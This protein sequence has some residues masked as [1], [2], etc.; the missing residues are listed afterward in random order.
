MMKVLL[1]RLRRSRHR[2]PSRTD[3]A[4]HVN[5]PPGNAFG[6]TNILLAFGSIGIAGLVMV[7]RRPDCPYIA[8]SG[9][10]GANRP[11]G[12][13]S[14]S[15]TG[16]IKAETRDARSRRA[17]SPGSAEGCSPASAGIRRAR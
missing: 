5:A 15:R 8:S 12:T 11:G 3:G 4:I 10:R 9:R 1:P 16:S 7:F 17:A 2:A 13:A 14:D 6:K